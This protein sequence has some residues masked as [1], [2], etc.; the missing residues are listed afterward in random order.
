MFSIKSIIALLVS[1]TWVIFKPCG[2]SLI[3][4]NLY[5]LGTLFDNASALSIVMAGSFSP[6]IIKK[7]HLISFNLC[8]IL[9]LNSNAR[10]GYFIFE[11]SDFSHISIHDFFED[12]L[13]SKLHPLLHLLLLMD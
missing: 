7:G 10:A 11:R 8:V 2:P 13:Q 6:C 1:L 9:S 12:H 4:R 3:L 5:K